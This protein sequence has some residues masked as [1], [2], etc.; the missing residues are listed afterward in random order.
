[1]GVFDQGNDV[2]YAFVVKDKQN[3]DLTE[4]KVKK[5]VN[6]K[7]NAE[8]SVKEVVFVDNFPKTPSGKVRRSCLKEIAIKIHESKKKE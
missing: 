8:K 7:V 4:E 5:F 6:G 2:V 1:V 3:Q